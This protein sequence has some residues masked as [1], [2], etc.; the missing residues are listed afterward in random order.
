MQCYAMQCNAMQCTVTG[1]PGHWWLCTALHYIA[2]HSIALHWIALYCIALHRI[3]LHCTALHCIALH[4]VGFACE[5]RIQIRFWITG[6]TLFTPLHAFPTVALLP[7]RNAHF[8]HFCHWSLTKSIK[9]F[10]SL[11]R[12]FTFARRPQRKSHLPRQFAFRWG[13]VTKVGARNSP[14]NMDAPN[15]LRFPMF[16]ACAP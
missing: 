2:L 11:L 7:Q 12:S 4:F 13:R 8:C 6:D 9:K 14:L 5:F 15:S 16:R 10:T 1:D 3:A